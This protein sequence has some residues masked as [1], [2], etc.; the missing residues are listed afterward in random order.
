MKKI[1]LTFFLTYKFCFFNEH[2]LKKFFFGLII[3]VISKNHRFLLTFCNLRRTNFTINFLNSWA[4]LYYTL[5]QSF[6]G[7]DNG[8]IHFLFIKKFC[9]NCSTHLIKLCLK[10]WHN[11]QNYDDL[12]KFTSCVRAILGERNVFQVIYF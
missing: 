4:N 3:K 2:L 12:S 8:A 5:P 10:L 9:S 1:F 7:T 11:S 6:H